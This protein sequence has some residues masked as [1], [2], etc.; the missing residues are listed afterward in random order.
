VGEARLDWADGRDCVRR[1]SGSSWWEWNDGS[2]PHFWR[3]PKEYKRAVRDGVQPWFRSKVPCW[4]VPQRGEKDPTIFQAMN[5]KLERVRRLRYIQEGTVDSLTSY[6]SVP[7]GTSDIRMVYDGTKSGLNDAM[8]AP[9]FALPTLESHLRFVGKDTFLGDIDIGDMFH[10]FVLH[11]R[12]QR[13]AGIDLTPFFSEEVARNANVKAFW[14][15][16]VR[17]AMGLK[18]SPYNAIQ[19]ILIAEEFIKGD[20]KEPG[21]VFRWDYLELNLPGD[22]GYQPGRSWITKRR[23]EDDGI[24]CDFVVYVDDTRS[25]G[26]GWAEARSVNRTIASKLNYLGLQEAAR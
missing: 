22:P 23:E 8:W 7:K 11:D 3:W 5:S 18:S 25:G 16:W 24:A 14:L 13:L 21:N 15:R 6:F 4:R 26:N 12:V 17:S 2:R 19:G 10:N 9:W 20:P 1:Y